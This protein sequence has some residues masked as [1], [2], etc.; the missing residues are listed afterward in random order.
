MAMCCRPGASNP[1]SPNSQF[2]EPKKLPEPPS[3]RHPLVCSDEGLMG[4]AGNDASGPL[5]RD[6]GPGGQGTDSRSHGTAR[7][8]Y[9]HQDSHQSSGPGP[10]NRGGDQEA[11]GG[12]C[13]PGDG[14]E[15]QGVGWGSGEDGGWGSHANGGAGDNA[16]GGWGAKPQENGWGNGESTG[17]G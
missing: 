1:V 15:A 16:G 10:G 14:A 3:P 8:P 4:G 7:D 12:G 2:W 9:R 11:Y 6:G 17:W 13:G 5:E